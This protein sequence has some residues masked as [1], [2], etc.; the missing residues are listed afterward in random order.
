MRILLV[1]QY[2]WPEF[3]IINDMVKTLAMQGHFIKVL[4]GKPNY[5]G[6]EIFDGYEQEGI[7]HEVYDKN[8]SIFRIPVRP[9]KAGGSK[10]LF[11]NYLSFIWNGM[12]YFPSAI[13]GETYDSILVF[14]P[15]PITS[16]IPA[17]YLKW[18]M[19]IHLAIWIQDLWPESL[20]A[21]GFIHNKLILRIVGWIVRAIY[22]GSDTLLVQSRAFFKPVSIYA[23]PA[24]VVYFPNAYTD[25]FSESEQTGESDEIILPE[26]L[27]D[28]LEKNFCVS[29]TGNLGTA[30]SL[31][32][33]VSAAEKLK[34]IKN[35][36]IILV[37]SGSMSNWL[38][39]QKKDRN[40][41]NLI[42][43]GHYPAS[44]MPSI[45]SRSQALLVT[46]KKNEIFSY[47]I[48][49]KV[50]A[51]LSSAKPIIAALDG[52]GARIIEEAGAGLTSPAEDVDGLV[53]AIKKIIMLSVS[54]RL[55]MGLAGRQ[56]YLKNFEM[57]K[58]CI[59]LISIL[60][61]RINI[62]KEK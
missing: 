45:F 32:T 31:Q 26:S 54:E 4:T 46:L 49:G 24:K 48:P 62:V 5:P 51:Y 22:T 56:Y 55:E 3:F 34:E 15:S 42:L 58:Q 47:T 27:I 43:A 2:F 23:N 9:R 30:Q 35:L 33:I 37:G 12:R 28:I 17:L 11:L 61:E 6:G 1:T 52:E 36:R 44:T 18:K 29:F 21:T 50:Q 16:A 8:V 13:K 14:A 19:K 57:K 10:N 7:E 41:H 59:Q 39:E 38:A 20:R 40:L 53:N 25:I 60:D